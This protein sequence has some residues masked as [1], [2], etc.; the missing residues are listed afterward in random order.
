MSM[1]STSSSWPASATP[2]RS[3]VEQNGQPT[4]TVFAPV[5]TA[6]SARSRL[7][8][9]PSGS[10]SHILEPPAPQQ[11]DCSAL[12]GISVTSEKEPSSSLGGVK[13]RL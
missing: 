1:T 4:A 13:I 2:S 11:K 5:A 8:R 12:R 6:S 9:L 3:I 10:S 7:T